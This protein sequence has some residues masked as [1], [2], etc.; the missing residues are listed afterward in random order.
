[1]PTSPAAEPLPAARDPSA[2]PTA[3]PGA[4][5]D[6]NIGGLT[7][8]E[9]RRAD[10]LWAGG[11][12]LSILLI[13]AMLRFLAP[14][15]VPVLVALAGAYS[16]DPAADWLERRGLSRTMAVLV[17]FA[18]MSL[19]IAGAMLYLVPAIGS[20]VAKL[21]AFF[22]D[23]SHKAIPR[24][25]GLLG[26]P[27]PADVRGAAEA[28]GEQGGGLAEKT[29]PSIA[30][31]AMGAL[32]STASVLVFGLG[33][34]VIPVLTFHLLRDYDRLVAWCQGLLPRR[35]EPLVSHRFGE[36]HAVLGGFLRGQLTVGAI[37]TCLYGLGLSLAGIDLAVVIAAVAGFGVMLPYIGPGFGLVLASLSLAV[38][39]QGPWQLGVVAATF[40]LG[41][42]A[43]G[44]Y[45]TPRVVGG[46]VGLS[47][48]VVMIAVLAFGNL[49][50]FAGVLLALP[51]TAAL[52]VVAQVVLLRYRRSR[53]YE[54]TP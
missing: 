41:M 10:L 3:L 5:F 14:A 21:P 33:L 18:V 40:G 32:S 44:L 17:L 12:T 46:K 47:A 43:E 27:L 16:L 24:L 2:A 25:E 49:F 22:R 28:L 37:L 51:V 4:S 35:Y 11:L 13:F 34:L 8:S 9:A 30:K 23:I 15:A 19:V 54:G 52:K 45:I 50:G 38:S 42:T 26:R 7:E 6:P 48:V 1:M 36:V 20:E 39:W 31:L 53:T 29:L